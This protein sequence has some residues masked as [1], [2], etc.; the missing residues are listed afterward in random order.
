MT[1]VPQR[2]APAEVAAPEVAVSGVL[3]ANGITAMRGLLII[4]VIQ[5]MLAGAVWVSTGL[6]AL[7]AVLD[8]ADGAIARA[9]RG[10]TTFGR[11]FD[12]AVDRLFGVA[13][14]AALS[15]AHRLPWWV[16]AIVALALGVQ[17][18]CALGYRLSL[19]PG[20]APRTAVGPLLGAVLLTYLWLPVGWS[21]R[22]LDVS[23]AAI[24]VAGL[25]HYL[26]SAPAGNSP[27]WPSVI[28]LLPKRLR[29][30]Y[31]RK[32]AGPVPDTRRVLTVPNLVTVIRLGPLVLAVIALAN[33]RWL[34]ASGCAAVFVLLDVVDGFLARQLNQVSALGRCLDVVVDK[35]AVVALALTL[36]LSGRLA[37][38]VDVV[39][40]IRIAVIGVLG[41]AL[42][43]S[44]T[45][46]PRNVWS[47]AANMA[48][49]AALSGLT[50]V[51]WLAFVLNAI[52]LTHYWST[53][54]RILE[55]PVKYSLDAFL[56][57]DDK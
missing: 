43:V 47:P 34:I 26:G 10:E 3:L 5:A 48:A 40:G 15:V 44:K 35:S 53:S 11:H 30:N 23:T 25:W 1:A 24:A 55:K 57:K 13:V 38:D 39:V 6:A 7:F 49:L 36:V 32:L 29:A 27:R 41:A 54:L 45:R 20:G 4:P 14:F 52:N 51:I 28:A 33:N 19:L 42:A 2:P 8:I 22:A 12:S 37:V 21:H 50:L 31:L 56:G 16:T 9:T 18:I 17:A 46:P